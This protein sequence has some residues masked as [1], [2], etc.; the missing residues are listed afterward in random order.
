[1]GSNKDVKKAPVDKQ[2]NVIEILEILMALKKVNQCKAMI[3]PANKNCNAILVEILRDRFLNPIYIAINPIA[4]TIRNQTKGNAS[5]EI[6]APNMAVNP[7][8]N[9]I[10]WR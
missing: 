1:M 4:K 8:I 3:N 2:A 5:R 10:R 7:H 9:T 6:N